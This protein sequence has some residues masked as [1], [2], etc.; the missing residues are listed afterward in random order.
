M[1]FIGGLLAGAGSLASGI[2]GSGSAT[3]AAKIQ[4]KSAN[5]ASADQLMVQQ[6][7]QQQLQPF[8]QTGG[9]ALTGLA[10][11][12]GV[13]TAGIPNPGGEF[14]QFSPSGVMGAPPPSPT[15]VPQLQPLPQ[16][17][18]P[19]FLPQDQFTASPGYQYVLD[20]SN[21][22][23]TNSDAAKSGAI[24]GNM[25]LDLQK[26]SAGLASQDYWTAN[27]AFQNN[28]NNQFTGNTQ[29]QLAGYNAYNQNFWSNYNAQN[30]N[31]FTQYNDTINGR[32]SYANQLQALV[33]GGQ[34]AA[35]NSGSNLTSAATNIGNN[36][37][38]AGNAIAA[39]VIGSNNALTGGFQGASS[40]LQT[41]LNPN[42]NNN[43]GGN[44]S[45]FLNFLFGSGANPQ[46][47]ATGGSDGTG[48][49]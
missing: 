31:Y 19:A 46:T 42:N 14:T 13:P 6:I 4:A 15:G 8:L 3:D 36:T 11:R 48:A 22:A 40:Y 21:K 9:N 41:L 2:I 25:L 5:T 29:N 16:Y 43:N 37:T 45:S 33:T 1:P 7:I 39:G 20:Q 49:L 12:L 30:Q 44:G 10:S 26:N 17:N 32:N 47:W 38:G 24:S 35:T 27:N 23:L 28:Y 34:N 18:A